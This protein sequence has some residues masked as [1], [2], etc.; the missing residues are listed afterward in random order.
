MAN[1]DRL[2]QE[3]I[4]RFRRILVKYSQ[5]RFHMFLIMLLTASVGAGTSFVLLKEGLTWMWLRYPIAAIIAYL[6]F[7]TLLRLWV[8]YKF[9]DLNLLPETGIVEQESGARAKQS[10]WG[11]IP[12]DL[13]DL[14]WGIDDFP[15]VIFVI[16]I[17][18]VIIVIFGI[19]IAAPILMSEVLVDGLLVAGLWHRFNRYG[20]ESSLGG[21][22]R[23]TILPAT[24]VILCLGI[25]G[26]FLQIIEPGADSIGD[27][28]RGVK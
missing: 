27:V 19:I 18:A 25:I 13:F 1:H 15:V 24:I 26:F 22:V 14:A 28:F 8:Q 16:A 7:L 10:I 3:Q 12:I 2:R 9:S 17:L 4:G 20:E 11:K 23:A 21:A 5:P 6:F